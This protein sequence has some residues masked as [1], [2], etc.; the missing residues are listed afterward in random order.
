MKSFPSP[1]ITNI[2]S[3]MSF[4]GLF[5][6]CISII[7]GFGVSSALP[8]IISQPQI[9]QFVAAC[10][11]FGVFGGMTLG[12]LCWPVIKLSGNKTQ[13]LKM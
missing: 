13:Q 9:S 11:A 1:T 2:E 8:T 10:I 7:I 4:G 3:A 6:F 12:A 5:G